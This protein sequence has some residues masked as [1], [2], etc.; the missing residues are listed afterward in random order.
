MNVIHLHRA[1]VSAPP[2][3]GSDGCAL[4]ECPAGSCEISN[5]IPLRPEFPAPMRTAED[6]HFRAVFW[7]IAIAVCVAIWSAIYLAVQGRA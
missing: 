2:C 1:S 7:R 3:P 4:C 5:T 6:N